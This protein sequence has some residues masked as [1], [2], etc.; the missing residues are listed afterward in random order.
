MPSSE[1][2]VLLQWN[3]YVPDF[4]NVAVTSTDCPDGISMFCSGIPSGS[5]RVKLC[6]LPDV[7][8]ILKVIVL[9]ARVVMLFGWN[10]KSLAVIWITFCLSPAVTGFWR[11][12]HDARRDA[13]QSAATKKSIL[14]F[15]VPP[16]LV[17][18]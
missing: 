15:M 17:F 13:R 10:V 5:L 9:P 2:P 16:V 7:F 3:L 4:E 11:C 8:W 12:V 6:V 14:V 18:G 1:W